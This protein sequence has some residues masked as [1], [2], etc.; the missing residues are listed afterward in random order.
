M[1]KSLYHNELIGAISIASVLRYGEISYAKSLLI[2]PL[3]FHKE[4]LDFLERNEHVDLEFMAA[5][6]SKLIANFNKRYYSLLSISINSILIGQELG[7]L[8]TI[9]GKVFSSQ[10]EEQKFKQFG[11]RLMRIAEVANTINNLLNISTEEAY[12]KLQIKL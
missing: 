3:L 12:F 5:N 1:I 10:L 2:L 11:N 8:K 9:N 4:T 7:F 6:K